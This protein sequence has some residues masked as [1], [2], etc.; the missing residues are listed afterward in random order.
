MTHKEMN[1]MTHMK[2]A[3]TDYQALS[4]LMAKM[5]CHA[6]AWLETRVCA[7]YTHACF[8]LFAISYLLLCFRS[9]ASILLFNQEYHPHK[10]FALAR[11]HPRSRASKAATPQ[12]DQSF[13]FCVNVY[14]MPSS[15]PSTQQLQQ[16]QART[17]KHG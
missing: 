14:F 13:V 7:R 1:C 2:Y 11:T 16:D 17:A 3:P 6:K 9:T 8:Q 4:A 12:A 10:R 5:S 15:P